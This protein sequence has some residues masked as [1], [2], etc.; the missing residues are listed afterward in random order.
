MNIKNSILLR[1]RL[2][3]LPM[4]IFGIAIVYKIGVI[5]FVEGDK[6]R[7]LAAEI[8]LEYRSVPATR[9]NIIS[10][11]GSLLATSIPFY[12]LALDPSRASKLMMDAGL[13]S[14]AAKLANFY[15]DNSKTTYKQR[16][17]NARNSGKRYVLLNRELIDYQEKKEMETWPIFREG[18]MGGG[19]L[20]TK[21]DK[22]FKPFGYLGNRSIGFINENGRGAD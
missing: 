11:N 6:W 7:S 21:V 5:Q 10:D 9:G 8:G 19:V 17:L 18:R 22:R 3:F 1:V 12:K 15:K 4:L 14:L 20:F 16:I 2:A 13:D